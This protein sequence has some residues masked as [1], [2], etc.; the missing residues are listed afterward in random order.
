MSHSTN[1]LAQFTTAIFFLSSISFSAVTIAQDKIGHV[2][3]SYGTSTAINDDKTRILRRGSAIYEGDMLSTA[4]NTSIQ[5]RMNDD[6]LVALKPN[7]KFSIN[8]YQYS[9]KSNLGSSLFSLIK[10]GFRT[11]TGL[12]GKKNKKNYRVKTSVATIGIR[13]THYGL[14]LCSQGNCGSNDEGVIKDGLYG[15]VI[16][17]EIVTN[18]QSGEHTF[19]ND[20]YF[21]I[22]SIN[23][24]PKSL[25]KPPGI[26]FKQNINKKLKKA[27]N[28]ERQF[29]TLLQ[30]KR[31]QTSDLLH[32]SFEQKKDFIRLQLIAK[33]EASQDTSTS[34][35]SFITPAKL[36]NVLAF[37]LFSTDATGITNFDIDKIIND[38]TGDNQFFLNSVAIEKNLFIPVAAK[39]TSADG[40]RTLFIADATPLEARSITIPGTKLTVGWGRWSNEYVTSLDG[41]KSPHQGQ[42]HYI[43]ASETTTLTQLGGLQGTAV[44]TSIAGTRA[45]DL[46]GNIAKSFADV[47]M[48]VD[49]ALSEVSF[50]NISTTIGTGTYQASATAVPFDIALTTGLD[51]LGADKI[52]TGQANLSFL[53]PNA[54]GAGV[55]YAINNG[56]TAINGAA[57]LT[58]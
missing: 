37:S 28:I 41:V 45:T 50:L 1:K 31:I 35:N 42:L 5:L 49:F 16:D 23:S 25:L 22:A 7:T 18:N 52:T 27:K 44:Y 40:T 36:G 32:A 53:G 8:Q 56:S 48:A 46:S 6:A 12:I 4:D 17:G 11:I 39:Q 9:K 38:G 29:S 33:F 43:V 54:E 10:G 14:T 3:F 34:L 24:K 21:H 47:S 30:A 13:G 2:I 19:S 51:L 55:V 20:E 15:S 58:R 26:I 57:I